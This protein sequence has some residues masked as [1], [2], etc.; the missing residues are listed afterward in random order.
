MLCINKVHLKKGF[1][2][3]IKTFSS[4]FTSQL[5]HAILLQCTVGAISWAIQA[6]LFHCRHYEHRKTFIFSRLLPRTRTLILWRARAET[7][8]KRFPSDKFWWEMA[9]ESE[10]W[11]LIINEIVIMLLFKTSAFTNGVSLEK[12]MGYF[13]SFE[14][15]LLHLKQ[16]TF[17]PKMGWSQAT[18]SVSLLGLLAKIKV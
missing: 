5:S 4:S 10:W 13:K 2:V 18:H 9:P 11:W 3:C 7:S 12:V 15:I 17:S 14:T 6:N 1:Y 8:V 16:K